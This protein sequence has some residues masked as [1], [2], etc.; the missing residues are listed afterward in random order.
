MYIC[1]YLYIYM[2]LNITSY[3]VPFG[4]WAA[5]LLPLMVAFE[6]LFTCLCTSVEVRIFHS[7]FCCASTLIERLSLARVP[8]AMALW[9]RFE[10][11]LL[12]KPLFHESPSS[13]KALGAA[14]FAQPSFR[15][16]LQI[17]SIKSVFQVTSTCCQHTIKDLVVR[18]LLPPPPHHIYIY[19]Y[20]HLENPTN[21]TR[22]GTRIR[23][24]VE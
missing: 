5:L 23:Q 2:L 8:Y 19:I 1:V 3:A 22:L 17:D 12:W 20:T 13:V 21:R 15:C 18:T 16:F 11:Q 9:R 6:K 7:H 14:H 10:I 24:L 4:L